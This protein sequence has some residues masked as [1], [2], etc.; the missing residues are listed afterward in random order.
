MTDCVEPF[1][2]I[3]TVIIDDI[4]LPDG[5]S[6]MG[7]LGGGVTHAVMGMR[8][9]TDEAAIIAPVGEDFP[10]DLWDRLAEHF[11]VR[12]LLRRRGPT[13]RAWQLFENDGKRSEVF[14]TDFDEMVRQIPA[15]DEFPTAFRSLQGMHLHCHPDQMEE[16]VHFLR[17][18]GCPVIL[19]EP[20]DV[21]CVP[22]NRERF[23]A[24]APLVDV[25]SP[26]L[27]EMRAMTG[28]DDPQEAVRALLDAGARIAAL[29]MG[30][31]GS[32][33]V[34]SAGKA[35]R[36]PALSIGA[37]VDITG[38]GN[39]YGAGFVVGL[40]RTGDLAR[41]GTYGAVSS[42]FALQQFGALYP[43]A[44]LREK[45]EARLD[46]LWSGVKPASLRC[47]S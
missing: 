35:V 30:G 41:A 24:L 18:R 15:P 9:W 40:A 33:V 12:G 23:R 4:I 25:V 44:G 17:E 21:F 7:E 32:L 8:V 29:R 20:W 13:P 47:G 16:W 42:S 34:D 14:R 22:E 37:P 3:G 27:G 26:N 46:L 2:S 36:V 5:Q 11:D 31:G 1:A 28:A 19:W 10:P 43:T 6:R 45:A 39:A 38:A